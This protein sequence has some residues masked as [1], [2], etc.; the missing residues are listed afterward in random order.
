MPMASDGTPLALDAGADQP[1]R[2]RDLRRRLRREL[3]RR[4]R[5]GVRRQRRR[6]R[7]PRPRLRRQRSQAPP[8]RPTS[9]RSPIRRTAAA[10]AS[11]RSARPTST[12]TSPAIRSCARAALRRRHRR[13]LPRRRQRSEE[14]H[15]AAS[16]TPTATA[17][18]RRNGR[19][20]TATTT[21]PAVHPGAVE[22]C[23]VDQGP[24]LQRHRR[25]RLRALRP[26]R[27]RLRAHR[28]GQRLPRRQRQAPGHARLQ[29]R[30]RGR[31]PRRRP[32]VAAA[33][34]RAASASARWRRALRGLCRGI[35]E[36]QGA[37]RHAED[38]PRSAA[39]S[40][41][42]TA[43]ARRSK[44][45]RPIDPGCDADGDGWPGVAMSNGR[46]ATRATSRST[47]TTTIRPSSRRR[48]S[49]AAN[50]PTVKENCTPQGTPD[51]T[52]DADGDGYAAPADCD[53]NDADGPPVGGRAL[54]R[55]GQRL[56]RP[57]RRR[58]PRS[59][60]Q[61]AGHGRR[62]HQ[63]HRLEHRRVRQDQGQLR[64]LDRAAGQGPAAHDARTTAHLLPRRR[65]A[66]P[67]RRSCFGA[68]QPKP[69]SCDA[70]QPEGRRLRRARRRPG[71]RATWRSRA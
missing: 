49:S 63:L 36:A 53:D 46:T 12:R 45:A 43:T 54:R 64:V 25:R 48:R 60:G 35:Y 32:S 68:G 38:R 18:R 11:A 69:Q 4:R 28:P 8:S 39:W 7:R 9:I 21:I 41:T 42:P 6:S 56:R 33:A 59:D 58:Q 1:V 26:R 55:Q 2:H 10:T 3:Q 51:C 50:R 47:A 27:R 16:S 19:A 65:R 24:Q 5:R 22:L 57:R 29:R 31:V 67:S 14:R 13:E 70:D 52:G 66:R 62:D 34:P 44:A 37:H 40:A 23:G 71:R 15:H 30:R 17:I 20:T 61:A